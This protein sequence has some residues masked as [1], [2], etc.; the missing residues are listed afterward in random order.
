MYRET[1]LRCN[2]KRFSQVQQDEVRLARIGEAEDLMSW[3]GRHISISASNRSPRA[4]HAITNRPSAMT[5]SLF[6]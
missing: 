4:K 5:L 2:D 3:N 1:G 6:R